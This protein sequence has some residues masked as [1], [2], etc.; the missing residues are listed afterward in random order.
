[1]EK[2]GR[3]YFK[4]FRGFNE[5]FDFPLGLFDVESVD[6]VVDDAEEGGGCQRVRPLPVSGLSHSRFQ[7]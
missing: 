1:M 6:C 3:P 5:W 2:P 4:L 7:V